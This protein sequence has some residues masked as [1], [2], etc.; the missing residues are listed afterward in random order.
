MIPAGGHADVG[1]AED[2]CDVFGIFK[3]LNPGERGGA[4][5]GLA[6]SKR[7]VERHGGTISLESTIGEGSRF[8]FTLP[9]DDGCMN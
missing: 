8:I 5:V 2:R 4:G 1:R 3:Q 9:A 7:I 6:I